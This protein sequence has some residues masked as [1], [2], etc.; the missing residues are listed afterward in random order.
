M[1]VVIAPDSFKECLSAKEVALNMALGVAE[2]MPE[3][4]I[5]QI[6]ISDGGEGMLEALVNGSQGRFVSVKVKDPL[7]RD[8]EAQYGILDDQKT[9]VIELAKAS[10]LDLLAEKE[11]DPLSTSTF[12]TGQLIKDALDKG[13]TKLIIGIG[14]SATNDA[15]TGMISALGARFLNA[16]GEILKQGGGSLGELERID[17]SDLDKRLADC[18]VLVACDVSNPLTGETGAS[19]VYGGQKGGSH[20]T[21][22]LLDK[23]LTHYAAILKKDLNIA[24]DTVPGSGAAGGTGAALMAFMGGKLT[25]GIGLVLDT[26]NMDEYLKKADVV[27]TGEGKIDQQTLYGKTIAGIAKMA[28]RHNVPVIVITGKIGDAIG[29]IYENGVTAVFSIVDQPME[30]EHAITDAPRL[31]QNCTKA[32]FQTIQRFKK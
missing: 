13:C 5:V 10:G 15:G 7:L 32:V 25:E 18:E 30:L 3:A 24:I 22:Q 14:G 16:K 9:A 27:I 8:I 11:K 21:L 28:K 6:P 31:I 17:I 12:G 29:G 1:N 4:E 23:N 20:E 2:I 26:L 19:F